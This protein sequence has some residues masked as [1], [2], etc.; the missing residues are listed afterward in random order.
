MGASFMT[1]AGLPEWVAEDDAG[2]VRVAVHMAQDRHALL[3]L[4][5][6]LRE[7][8]QARRGWNVVA[9]TRAMEAAFERM[10]S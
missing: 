2:Y 9:H 1:A 3:H 4:K 5:R 10:V 7:R 8:L 6:G